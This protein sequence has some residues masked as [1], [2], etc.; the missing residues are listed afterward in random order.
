MIIVSIEI[1]LMFFVRPVLLLLRNSF[2]YVIAALSHFLWL[3]SSLE[4]WALEALSFIRL[5]TV[6]PS[7]GSW[8]ETITIYFNSNSNYLLENRSKSNLSK[9]KNIKG[10]FQKNQQKAHSQDFANAFVCH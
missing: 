3:D 10:D 5:P 4:A 8:F 6:P 2:N 9:D 1:V 7:T